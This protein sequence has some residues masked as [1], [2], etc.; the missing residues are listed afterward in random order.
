MTNVY[1]A[2]N[3]LPVEIIR[4]HTKG[5]SDYLKL[6]NKVFIAHLKLANNVFIADRS[7]R[8]I[9]MSTSQLHYFMLLCTGSSPGKSVQ[10]PIR[11]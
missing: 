9:G 10:A 4:F 3:N 6:D 1:I 11:L 5:F 2:S 7:F 8:K